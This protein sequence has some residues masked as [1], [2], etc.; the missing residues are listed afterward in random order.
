MR[1]ASSSLAERWRRSS[2]RECIGASKAAPY[3]Q[4]RDSAGGGDQGFNCIRRRRIKASAENRGLY[5][6]AEKT[7]RANGERFLDT[8]AIILGLGSG[9]LGSRVACGS[10]DQEEDPGGLP[11]CSQKKNHIKQA[12]GGK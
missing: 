7:N 10:E 8:V 1:N 12:G 2:R 11:R 4:R 9:G 6:G 5:S 3:P